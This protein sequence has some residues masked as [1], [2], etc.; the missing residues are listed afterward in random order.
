MDDAVLVSRAQ[1]VG[2]LAGEFQGI[3]QLQRPLGDSIFRILPFDV[4]HHNERMTVDFINFM[5]RSDVWMVDH[6]S[7][8]GWGL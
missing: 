3:P 5:D 1:S 8:P 4:G 7:C 2:K 6:S